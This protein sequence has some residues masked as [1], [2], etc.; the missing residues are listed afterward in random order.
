MHSP[1]LL[2]IL[3]KIGPVTGVV[4]TA[5]GSAL[6]TVGATSVVCAVSGQVAAPEPARPRAGYLGTSGSLAGLTISLIA[7]FS[8]EY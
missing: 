7:H 5:F 1:N 3:L 4:K 8:P 6:A 2:L